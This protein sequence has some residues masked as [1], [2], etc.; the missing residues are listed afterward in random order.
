MP[1]AT[2]PMRA[3]TL[4]AAAGWYWIRSGFKL[5]RANPGFINFL[6]FSTWLMV[7]GV[8]LLPLIGQAIGSLVMP[9]L[10]VGI[11]HGCRAIDRGEK[12]NPAMLFSGFKAARASVLRIGMIYLLVSSLVFALSLMLTSDTLQPLLS[13]KTSPTEVDPAVAAQLLMQ[14]VIT[15]QVALVLSSPTLVAAP[16]A[17]WYGLPVGK[18]LFFAMIGI[19]RNVLPLSVLYLALLMLS[20]GLPYV[21]AS[22]IGEMPAIVKTLGQLALMFALAFVFMPT[23]FASFYLAIRD[24]FQPDG[25]PITPRDDAAA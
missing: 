12:P 4:P 8:S 16:L 23:A 5:F 18:A 2:N 13:G 24:I 6:W 21:L 3:E 10:L 22:V 14:L 1:L 20:F 11:L 7:M 19:V 25:G 17:A 15:L 9:G